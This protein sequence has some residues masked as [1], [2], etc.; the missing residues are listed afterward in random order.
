MTIPSKIIDLTNELCPDY[1]GL[2]QCSPME[3]LEALESHLRGT[4]D[5]NGDLRTL[6]QKLRLRFSISP[7][8]LKAIFDDK[9][10]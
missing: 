5:A 2:D 6:I 9:N 3:R 10:P 8:E 4:M 7:E 1:P